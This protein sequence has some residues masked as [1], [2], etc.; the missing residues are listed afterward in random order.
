MSETRKSR[1]KLSFDSDDSSTCTL[2]SGHH[3][4]FSTLLSW[5]SEDARR[6][7]FN[8]KVSATVLCVGHAEKRFQDH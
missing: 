3:T 4:Q 5:K 8:L 7:V 1:K 6:F 2:C